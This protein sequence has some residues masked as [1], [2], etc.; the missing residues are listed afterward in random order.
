MEINKTET[1]ANFQEI[2]NFWLD[3]SINSNESVYNIKRIAEHSF[4]EQFSNMTDSNVIEKRVQLK[5]GSKIVFT[6]P[7][8][9]YTE[10]VPEMHSSFNKKHASVSWS[11]FFRYKPYCCV[12]PTKKEK[13]SCLCINCL[14]PLLLLQLI[15]IF[16]KSKGLPSHYSLTGYT[17]RLQK[18]ESFEEANGDTPFNIKE[19]S[20]TTLEKK[21][22]LL[23]TKDLLA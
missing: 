2:N 10:S 20:K 6:N 9:I 19:L 14:N 22:N 5:K 18:G 16:R 23:S 12:R 11:L 3:S 1:A 7:R 17:D 13:L 21:G 8:M 4:L 15:N